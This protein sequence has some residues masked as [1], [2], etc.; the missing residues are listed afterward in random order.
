MKK[1]KCLVTGAGGGVG[2]GIIK[3]LKAIDDLEIEVIAA[4]MSALS[5]GLFFT[6]N[7]VLVPP[8]SSPDYIAVISKILKNH[9]VNYYFPGTDV[10]LK[11][12]L[13]NCSKIEALSGSR[14]MVVRGKAVH[15]GDDK[16]ETAT[17]L[18]NQGFPFPNT[19]ILR[20]ISDIEGFNLPLIIKPRIGCRSIGVSIAYTIDDVMSRLDDSQE[21][22]VQELI[23]HSG[24]E[25]TCTV[26]VCG[27]KVI[28]SL[29]LKRIL[30][31]G[32]TYRAEPFNCSIIQKYIES[33]ALSLAV[34]GS[35]N[36]QLRL[37]GYGVPKI[38]EIN[39]RFSGTTPFCMLLG[40][41]PVEA[42]IKS[43][44]GI[45]YAFSIDYDKIILRYWQE[46]VVSKDD[47][48]ALENPVG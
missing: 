26:V 43:L 2:Q 20:N 38:F 5:C 14:V 17:F 21:L 7:S 24:N 11:V 30:R 10:E 35:V 31:A 41:N 15:V 25:F 23:G 37:D 34:E 22:I 27:G 36:F 39:P 32:D 47:L 13:D 1:I 33:V 46:V 8:V 6:S 45:P 18:K 40:F 12:C 3:S 29:I 48:L 9:A 19:A 28:G 44:L 42:Y 16:F 4:D